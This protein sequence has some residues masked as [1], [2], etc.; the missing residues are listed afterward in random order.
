MPGEEAVSNSTSED[1]HWRAQPMIR[2][3]LLSDRDN[4]V[5]RY[6]IFTA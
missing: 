6:H 4:G 3:R 1:K 5:F 2:R